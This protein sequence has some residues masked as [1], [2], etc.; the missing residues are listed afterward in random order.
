MTLK[1]GQ[2][3][4]DDS[5]S[6]HAYREAEKLS[7]PTLIDEL[8]DYVKQESNMDKRGAAYFVIGKLG[9]QVRGSDCVQIL[10][11]ALRKETD[12][13]ELSRILDRLAPLPKPSETD[14]RTIFGLLND[15]R[16]IVRHAAIQAL[17]NTESPIAEDHLLALLEKTEDLYDITYINSTLSNMG[18]PKALPYIEKN[19]ASRKRDVK[20]SAQLAIE[21]I[22]AK[23][24]PI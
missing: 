14:L 5:K 1:E 10:L 17:A 2:V 22:R 7:D 13:N 24:L 16:W 6:W 20:Y 19:L 12:R 23:N 9:M 21:T 11:E 3:N 15:K 18:T 8:S 4:S